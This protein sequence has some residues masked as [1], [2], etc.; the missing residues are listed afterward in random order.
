M[1]QTER[2]QRDIHA[3]AGITQTPGNGATRPT[4]S[5]EWGKARDY[6]AD[7]AAKAGCE[8]RIDA[9]GNLH[10]RPATLGWNS[11]AWLCGSHI[12]TVPHGGDFDG[13]AGVVVALEL[14]RSAADDSIAALPMELIVFAEEEGPTFGL[15]MLGSRAWV[16]ELSASELGKLRNADGKTYLEAGAPFGVDANRLSVDR[17]HPEHFAGL[18][19]VHI[20]QGPG[21]WQRD[22]RLA[23]VPAIAGRVQLH[24]VITGQAN[25]AGATSMSDR[26][27]ALA[28]AAE[29]IVRLECL[30]PGI[31]AD[32]VITVGRIA[33]YPNAVNVIPDRVEFT[34][35]FRAGDDTALAR[36]N[37]A[38]EK[39][40]A[41][42][43][44]NR[45]LRFDLKTTESI[46][47]S[48][49]DARMCERLTHAAKFAGHAEV[50]RVVSGALH[51]S[52][53]LAR[54][55]PTAMLFIPSRDG[56]S[57][58]P[59]E[60]SRVED[61][62]AAAKVVQE[63]VRRPTLQMINSSSEA[64]FVDVAGRFFEQSPQYAQ[65]AWT[66][67]PFASLGDLHEKLC[68]AVAESGTEAQLALVRAHPDLVGKLARQGRL[69]RESTSEQSAAGLD[70]LTSDEIAAF[71]RY[72]GEY[73]NKFGFPF[74]ICARENRK[75][76]I[77]AAFPKRLAN[78]RETELATALT[79]IYK[80]ARLRLIDA[81]W[82]D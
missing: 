66:R 11:P 13:V 22:Q 1:I 27:D 81:I 8:I 76:A 64:Y 41:E 30:A 10:A 5:A 70:A 46:P 6:V 45:D 48:P 77:F 79:E 31:S 55:V 14:L 61:I 57:H 67:R 3:I 2:I 25:H 49:M 82:E 62:S 53:I 37:E 69:T 23:I 59:A 43:C 74:V 36:G 78:D 15:G 68:H 51:D 50:P 24:A 44:R 40:I 7:Q 72:N 39:L 19:E 21:M 4:F 32:T 71:E 12:D 17:I 35:D 80:I 56:I 75:E 60:F 33:N 9:A 38:I 20:E 52:A 26:R 34:I 54:H 73:R 28:G 47:A 63:L 58:N 16:G 65:L 18:I 42:I 29:I